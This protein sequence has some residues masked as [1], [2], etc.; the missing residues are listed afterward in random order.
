MVKIASYNLWN[1][2]GET[3][4]RLTDFIKEQKFDVLCLQEVNGWQDK[5][6]ARLKDF[7]DRDGYTDYQ[8]GN[9]NSEYKLATFSML[10]VVSQTVHEEGFWHCVVETHVRFGDTELAIFNLHL[11]PW[12][13]EPRL[14]EVEKLL[15]RIDASKP[16]ILTG[17]FN[18]LSR[19]DNYPPEFLQELQ[20][21]GIYKYGQNELD[22]GVT[23][24]LASAGFVD[25]AAQ[26][27]K[28]DKTVPSPYSTD[29]EH[30]VPARIDYMFVS[31]SLKPLV[32]DF[33]VIKNEATDKI[34]DHYPV[35]LTLG[36]QDELPAAPVAKPDETQ[37]ASAPAPKPEN[38]EN[39]PENTATE[40]E[41][42][43]HH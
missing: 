15:S 10:P 39:E 24:R 34:S 17:D 16:T 28:F 36:Q 35:V 13:E 43:V 9:S 29:P 11:D 38:P 26:S 41:I 3:Y 22:F 19:Q 2:A 4:F 6:F 31:E 12:K 25:V 20:R 1:G 40:G 8:Y 5:N 37:I 30:E 18:S 33:A 32:R 21:R 7:A 23:D 42:K 27:S 14:R